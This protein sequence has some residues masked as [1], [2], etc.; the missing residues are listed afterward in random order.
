MRSGCRSSPAHQVA[1][2]AVEIVVERIDFHQP[3]VDVA[4]DDGDGTPEAGHFDSVD[5]DAVGCLDPRTHHGFTCEEPAGQLAGTV[6]A[7]PQTMGPV[8]HEIAYGVE[9]TFGHEPTLGH[10]EHSRSELLDLVE[11][12]ARH[13]HGAAGVAQLSE[14]FD[15][16]QTLARIEAFERFIEH[17]HARVV[18]E[19]VGHL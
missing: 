14:Q 19:G 6:G 7:H 13:Q 10:H 17:H 8:I 3:G 9:V 4:S 2:H 18:H 11:D 1:E 15:H 5:D 16:A 12:M